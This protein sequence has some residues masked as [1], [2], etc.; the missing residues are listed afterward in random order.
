MGPPP[1]QLSPEQVQ[2]AV[3]ALL[4]FVGDQG[5]ND[6]LEDDELLYLVRSI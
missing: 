1:K 4:K 6:L 5:G 3:A 2:K